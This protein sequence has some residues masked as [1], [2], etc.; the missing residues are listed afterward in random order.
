MGHLVSNHILNNTPRE[1]N[2]IK[3]ILRLTQSVKSSRNCDFFH[4]SPP[5][6]KNHLLFRVFGQDVS[7]SHNADDKRVLAVGKL[8]RLLRIL[9]VAV[10]LKNVITCQF[11]DY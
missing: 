4:S 5:C 2:V 1:F 9:P 6:C 7:L 8:T 11:V 3:I 10:F